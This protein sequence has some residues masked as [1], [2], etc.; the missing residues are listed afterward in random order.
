VWARALTFVFAHAD[1]QFL[2]RCIEIET[3]LRKR[4]VPFIFEVRFVL[5]IQVPF[6]E[7]VNVLL[8]VLRM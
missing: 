1:V 3:K 7:G 5:L 4:Q 6:D 8:H 2:H